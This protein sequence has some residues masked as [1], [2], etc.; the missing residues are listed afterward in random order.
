MKLKLNEL[1]R[2]LVKEFLNLA[3]W[4]CS[5]TFESEVAV[6]VA[7]TVVPVEDQVLFGDL[8]A[9]LYYQLYY[10]IEVSLSQRNLAWVDVCSLE[11]SK[12]E[13]AWSSIIA[14]RAHH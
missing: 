14:V 6:D 4:S 7:Q 9:P 2:I 11:G 3:S 5:E 10:V 8:S 12:E 13:F 1:R